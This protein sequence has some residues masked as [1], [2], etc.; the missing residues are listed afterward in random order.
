MTKSTVMIA[1]PATLLLPTVE[2]VATLS[3]SSATAAHRRR[4]RHIDRRVRLR[5][6]DGRCHL[7]CVAT[8]TAVVVASVRL[9]SVLVAQVVHVSHWTMS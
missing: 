6:S 3:C 9:L 5:T 8:S 4:R 2:A 1:P 7:M